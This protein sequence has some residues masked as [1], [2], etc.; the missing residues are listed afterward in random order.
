MIN[1]EIYGR[2]VDAKMFI[3]VNYHEPIVLDQVARK[4]CL[5]PFYF[6]RTF[7][8]IYRFTPHQYVTRKR[9]EKA[10]QLLAGNK[11]V[12]EVCLEV[13]FESLGSFSSLFKK[14]NGLSPVIFRN[15]AW[16]QKQE[17][18]TEPRKA[19]PHCF[20]RGMGLD[21]SNNQETFHPEEI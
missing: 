3:D 8:N 21:K 9:M 4:A 6:H 16:L 15:V 20:I 11:P 5:S 1:H 14:E 10:K 7:K 18:I 12:T 17:R 13:G 19:I 2:V